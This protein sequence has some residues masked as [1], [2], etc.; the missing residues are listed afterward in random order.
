MKRLAIYFAC[1]VAYPIATQAQATDKKLA[2]N[3]ITV[4]NMKVEKSESNLVLDMDLNMSELNLPSNMRFVFT[5]MVKTENNQRLMPQ[6]I[7]SGR[8][9]NISFQRS[10]HNDYADDVVAVRRKNKTEQTV[11]YTAVLPYEEWMRNSDV[12]IAEDLCGCNKLMDQNQVELKKM[13]QPIIP[14]V[15]PAAEARKERHEEGR[16][17]ID[18]PVNKTDLYPEYRKNPA[19]LRKIIETINLVKEDKNTT[20]TNIDIH[21]YASPEGAYEHNGYLAKSRANTLKDYVRNLVNIPDSKFSV[22]STPEDWKGLRDYVAKGTLG[23]KAEILAI[24]DDNSLEPDAKEWKIK[25]TYPEEYRYM[26]DNWYPA[27]R[28]SDY[29]VNYTVR[30]F[31]VDEAKE[32]L[33]TKPR[34]LSLEEMFLV[35]QTYDPGTTE[36][37]EVMET[38]VL[39][40]PNNP[41]ANI[42]AACARMDMGDMEGAKVYLDKAG[43]TPDAL[44]AKGVMEIIQGDNQS[45]YTLLTKAVQGGAKGAADNL[46]LLER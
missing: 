14:Y 39:I 34:Q 29:V 6:I 41:T 33:K 19:E 23:H 3:A 12:V 10:G 37:D 36:F 32:I 25:A 30:P 20:I 35:A 7:V 40:Y 42:N 26:L 16:A 5:P 38:A 15:R 46:S 21:G 17:F 11:H 22:S 44:H 2:G 4:E 43:D 18:F 28:H 9:S 24:I 1:L 13:R 27:L 31:S 8:K 45:A